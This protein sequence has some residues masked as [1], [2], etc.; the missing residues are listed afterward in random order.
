[1]GDPQ[2]IKVVP[3]MGTVEPHPLSLC[4]FTSEVTCYH[5]HLRYDKRSRAREELIMD[6]NLGDHEL[7]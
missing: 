7:T 2:P 4:Y 5:T 1:M 6:Q 3:E